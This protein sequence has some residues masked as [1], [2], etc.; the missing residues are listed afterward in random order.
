MV[1]SSV[2]IFI[3]IA[4]SLFTVWI[5]MFLMFWYLPDKKWFYVYRPCLTKE[6]DNGGSV[7]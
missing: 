7:K 4:I 1:K 6:F 2:L 5:L 3:E